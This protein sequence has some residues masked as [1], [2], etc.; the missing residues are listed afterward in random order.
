MS[1]KRIYI[2]SIVGV[3]IIA[4]TIGAVLLTSY[5]SL[6]SDP[7]LLPDA[8]VA[9]ERPNGTEQ[10]ALDRVEV[11]PDTI[12]DVVSTLLRPEVYS[13]EVIIETF[14]DGG[15]AAYDIDVSVAGGVTSLRILPPDGI[16]KRI[17][18]TPDELFIWHR[19]DRVPFVGGVSDRGDE[20]RSADEW[21]MLNTYEDILEL[22]KSD[23]ID[24]G[25]TEFGGDECI[26]VVYRSREFGFLRKY[27][28]SIALGLVT[29]AEEFDETG[30]LIFSM[31]AGE[32]VIGEVDPAMFTLPD[33]TDLLI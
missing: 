2:I 10:D 31:T 24:A 32:S 14:W 25:Y 27:Y 5:L 4:A 29:G 11:T 22:D 30:S 16:E 1:T 19:G 23:I 17:I 12:Q 21:H 6:D 15:Q 18:V 7:V 33:G 20:H 9:T 26:F 28:I 8:P 13:R 3:L